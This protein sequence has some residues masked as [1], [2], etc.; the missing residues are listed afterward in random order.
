MGATLLSCVD[1][2][3]VHIWSAWR[4]HV[5]VPGDTLFSD[6]LTLIILQH[7]NFYINSHPQVAVTN[8]GWLNKLN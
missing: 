8:R 3:E 6:Q 2:V 1:H 7:Y 5:K 4:E